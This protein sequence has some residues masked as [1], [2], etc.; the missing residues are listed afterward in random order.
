MGTAF[1]EQQDFALG[2]SDRL[3]ASHEISSMFLQT[4]YVFLQSLCSLRVCRSFA[5]SH[6]KFV[7]A[8]LCCSAMCRGGYRDQW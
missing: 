6:L 8:Y 7:N 5:M 4:T 2:L 3:C 1:M